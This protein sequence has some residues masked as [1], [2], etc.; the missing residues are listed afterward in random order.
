MTPALGPWID[1]LT[2]GF[3]I[4]GALA[5]LI[6]SFGLLRLGNFFQRVHAP[7]LAATVGTWGFTI[8]TV[9]QMSFAA[10]ELY[11][12]A[13]LVAIFIALTTPVST[14]LLMRA[15]VFRARLRG[16]E[17]VPRSVVE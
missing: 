16:D 11:V 6:G 9:L 8:A 10:G 7:T 17:T 12:H 4:V 3:V 14:V 13:I 15:A 1:A 2:A 5:A